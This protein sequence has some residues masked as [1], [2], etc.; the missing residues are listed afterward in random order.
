MSSELATKIFRMQGQPPHGFPVQLS[1]DVIPNPET[2]EPMA[3]YYLLFKNSLYQRLAQNRQK[4]VDVARW[5]KDTHDAM[6]NVGFRV[7]IQP[8]FDDYDGLTPD[9]ASY[10]KQ[11]IVDKR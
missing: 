11:I 8:I 6:R 1:E 5:L 7:I 2:K 3:V 4:L 10:K 9:S